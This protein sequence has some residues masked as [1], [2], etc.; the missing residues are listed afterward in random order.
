MKQNH[1]NPYRYID[2]ICGAGKTEAAIRHIIQRVERYSN[3]FVFMM[4]TIPLIEQTALRFGQLGYTGSLTVIHGDNGIT[5]VAKRIHD[6]LDNP[7]AEGVLL[8]TFDGWRWVKGRNVSQWHLIVDECPQVFV[9]SSIDSK[10]IRDRILPHV[11]VSAI[12]GTNYSNVSI[13]AGSGAA[14]LKLIHES[15]S[16]QAI[17]CLEKTAT[18]LYLG[19]KTYV[20]TRPFEAYSEGKA[21]S[22]TFYHVT[23]A[24][25]VRGFKSV[26]IMGANFTHSELFQLWS[27]WGVRFKKLEAFRNQPPLPSTHPEAIG[28]ALDIHYLC[29]E[30]SASLKKDHK[31]V[32]EAEF[33]RAVT[34]VFAG[35]KFIY[36]INSGDDQHLLEGMPNGKHVKPKAHGQNSYREYDSAAIYAHFNLSTDQAAFLKTVFDLEWQSLWDLRNLDIYYQFVCRTSLREV[37]SAFSD[38]RPKKIVVMDKDMAMWL[39]GLFPGSRVHGFQSDPIAQLPARVT[40]RPKNSNAKS[41]AQRAHDSRQ[42]KKSHDDQR[43]LEILQG[44]WVSWTKKFHETRN[45]NTLE[46]SNVTGSAGSH[47]RRRWPVSLLGKLKSNN[48]VTDY[49]N[50]FDELVDLLRAA[51]EQ[52]IARK[53][54]NRL[55]NVTAFEMEGD[56]PR[57][58]KLADVVYS[59]AIFLDM[60][61]EE[62]NC[63]PLEFASAF[64]RVEMVIYSTF[65][66]MQERKRW[67]AVLPLSR[68]V[69][70]KEYNGIAKDL[71]RLAEAMGFPFDRSKKQANDFM[72][73]PC[74][75]EEKSAS[76]FQHFTGETRS[77][78]DV[79]Q[80]LLG[81][82][83]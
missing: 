68:S 28:E 49:V 8:I 60:D 34:E 57:G 45:E 56:R 21:N 77:P 5:S 37:P 52:E 23:P 75:S 63:C 47:E 64:S 65:S 40:G 70:V 76:F 54:E 35:E 71:I 42:K 3:K 31:T 55:F 46:G 78:L 81:S 74:Q 82:R 38:V 73:L 72:Y 61:S 1:A 14:I 17:A 13:K 53:E 44:Q 66:S 32:L 79:D 18:R 51:F 19:D 4:P 48:L 50:S 41:G 26:T 2:A 25:V 59:S 16:D 22:V 29:D 80:W 15:R 10:S 67:R 20:T 33:R 7:D 39:H 62:K 24:S 36:T 69:S 6:F 12:A 30:F 58:R 9:P 43:K 27:H 83:E 11:E